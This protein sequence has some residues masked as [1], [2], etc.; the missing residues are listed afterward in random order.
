MR[1]CLVTTDTRPLGPINVSSGIE[2]PLLAATVNQQYAARHG[3]AYLLTAYPPSMLRGRAFGWSKVKVVLELMLTHPEV[4]AFVFLDAD[5]AMN[6]D[7][8]LEALLGPLFFRDPGKHFFFATDPPGNGPRV[9]YAKWTDERGTTWHNNHS[10][11]VHTCG[12]FAARNTPLARRMMREWWHVPSARPE[13]RMYEHLW[14]HC[15]RAWDDHMRLKYPQHVAAATHWRDFNSPDGRYVQHEWFKKSPGLMRR[16]KR[17]LM[18]LLDAWYRSPLVERRRPGGNSTRRWLRQPWQRG[19]HGELGYFPTSW[20]ACAPRLPYG[21]LRPI[22]AQP[23]A[24]LHEQAT[25]CRRW[26]SANGAV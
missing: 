17:R 22:S 8:P 16:W 20:W 13:L 2:S 12:F 26:S 15:Q 6:T 4:E 9:K 5:S 10:N 25:H 14:P 19:M 18:R 7:T 1:L 3:Y 23:T 11:T 24:R 21:N